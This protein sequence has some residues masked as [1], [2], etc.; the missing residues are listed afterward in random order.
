MANLGGFI[1]GFYTN[2][3]N[4]I[5]RSL[6]DVI[7]EPTRS[8]LIP[9]F[10]KIKKSAIDNGALG[11]GIAGSGP[12]IY[13]MVKGEKKARKVGEAMSEILITKI[14]LEFNLHVSEINRNGI[15]VLSKK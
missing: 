13:A 2:D 9:E 1:C 14:G 10:Y 8:I 12:S 6:K 4:L 3:F 5:K 11:S 7:V 15:K